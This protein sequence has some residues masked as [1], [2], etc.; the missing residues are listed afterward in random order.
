MLIDII[1]VNCLIE[2]CSKNSIHVSATSPNLEIIIINLI[3][4]FSLSIFR[5]VNAEIQRDNKM[6]ILSKTKEVYSHYKSA[7]FN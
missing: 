7:C 1:N 3:E 6:K 4:T 2:K 5:V